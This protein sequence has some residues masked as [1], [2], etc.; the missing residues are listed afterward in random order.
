MKAKKRTVK[1]TTSK[2]VKYLNS[3]GYTKAQ[4]TRIRSS[5]RVNKLALT[6]SRKYLLY[7]IGCFL[8]IQLIKF[9]MYSVIYKGESDPSGM[10]FLFFVWFQ[11]ALLFATFIFFVLAIFKALTRIISETN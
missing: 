10:V 7:A 11:T 5:Q 2:G 8:A 1:K 4:K 3:S 9:V 6:K